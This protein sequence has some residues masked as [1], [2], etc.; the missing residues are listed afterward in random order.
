MQEVAGD[1]A[2]ERDVPGGRRWL[3]WLPLLAAAGFF[4]LF[5]R[6]VMVPVADLP[7][8]PL[9]GRAAPAFSLA[10]LDGTAPVDSAT[11]IGQGRPVILNFWA[12]WCTACVEEAADLERLHR[13]GGSDH[14]VL[15]IAIQDAPADARRF[16]RRHGMSYPILLDPQ[17]RS[18]I[19][20]GMLGVPETFVIDG[21][22]VVRRRFIGA[23]TAA[24]VHAALDALRE[25][26][27]P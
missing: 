5:I 10:P 20:Y 27:A 11:L 17:G 18:G 2:S 9:V 7:G 3:R 16:A 25:T 23:V 19:D 22:G 4:A 24:Q 6:A 13:E 1:R 21:N 8:S 15:G 14:L 12:S 26:A